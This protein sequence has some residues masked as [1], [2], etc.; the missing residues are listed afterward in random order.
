MN[1]LVE[2]KKKEDFKLFDFYEGYCKI[3]KRSSS[4]NP[5]GAI[6][7]LAALSLTFSTEFSYRQKIAANQ[8]GALK[9]FNSI[10]GVLFCNF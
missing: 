3:F 6:L 4:K 9:W 1:D 2:H 5:L 7:F 10:G 8:P